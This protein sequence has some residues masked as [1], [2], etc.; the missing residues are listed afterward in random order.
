MLSAIEYR[1]RKRRFTP[2]I[3]TLRKLHHN[4]SV[5][6]SCPMRGIDTRIARA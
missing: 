4:H 3:S 5:A 2:A 6:A 1:H